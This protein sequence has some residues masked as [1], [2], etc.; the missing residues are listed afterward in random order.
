MVKHICDNCKEEFT[1]KRLYTNHLKKV[2]CNVKKEDKII[3]TIDTTDTTDTTDIHIKIVISI[4]I[5]RCLFLRFLILFP[6]VFL[7]KAYYTSVPICAKKEYCIT[8]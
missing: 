1:Q 7:K 6:S 3:D 2:S 4:I 5:L 8:V